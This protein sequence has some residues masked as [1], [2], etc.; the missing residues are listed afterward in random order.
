MSWRGDYGI[1][2]RLEIPTWFWL[3]DS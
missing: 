3:V 2:A 1:V